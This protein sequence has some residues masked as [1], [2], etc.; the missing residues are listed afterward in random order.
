MGASISQRP[1]KCLKS[2]RAKSEEYLGPKRNF[3]NNMGRFFAPWHNF[4][5]E[6]IANSSQENVNATRYFTYSDWIN[7]DIAESME[8]SFNEIHRS[9]S[10]DKND[11]ENDYEKL[12]V[13]NKNFANNS[14]S[15]NEDTVDCQTSHAKLVIDVNKGKSL[16][17][18]HIY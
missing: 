13:A 12:V 11:Y 3:K 16:C 14:I 17:F 10:L 15:A 2:R 6:S 8:K 5:S 9:N 7:K 1:G 4:I 18:Q